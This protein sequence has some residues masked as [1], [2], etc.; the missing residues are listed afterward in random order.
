MSTPP[1][2][3]QASRSHDRSGPSGRRRA[4]LLA[5]ALGLALAAAAV[6][7]P[8]QKPA[9]PAA[10]SK[11][12]ESTAPGAEPDAGDLPAGKVFKNIKVLQDVRAAEMGPIMHVMRA[13]L[14]VR[15]DYCHDLDHYERDN[16]PAKEITREMLRMVF[17]INKENFGGRQE[18]TCETCHNG[19]PEPARAPAVERGFILGPVPP[20]PPVKLPTAT[21]LLDR[22]IQALGGRKALEAVKSRVSH[23]TLVH[24]KVVG[25]GTPGMHGI[26]RGQEDPLTIVESLPSH[27]VMTFGPPDAEVTEIF[28]GPSVRVR[29]AAGEHPASAEDAA[30]LANRFDL[31]REL[32]LRDRADSSRV[33]GKDKIDGRDVYLLRTRMPDGNAA[34]LAFDVE[35]G[36]LRRQTV[37]HPTAVG[38]E[39]E[40]TDFEDY[41]DVGG[42]KVPFLVNFFPLD[43]FH[44]GNTRKLT[45]VRD[46]V[47]Q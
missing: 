40:R 20:P 18:V 11:A 34:L 39:P 21:E 42:V 41:R 3:P 12:P 38:P 13:S 27:T 43:D 10:G 16:I 37:Y 24:L 5:A 28:D 22:Y 14:G 46:N 15:C 17:A 8:A 44:A 47:P 45:E 30:R 7:A 1:A 31:R 33:T 36:L 23:G 32:K 9:P 19:H 2:G 26:N 25:A 35:T 6:R 29:T 4:A